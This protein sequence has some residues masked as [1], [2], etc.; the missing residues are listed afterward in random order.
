MDTT[1]AAG[2]WPYVCLQ[3]CMKFCS[4]AKNFRWSNHNILLSRKVLTAIMT[5]DAEYRPRCN[6]MKLCSQTNSCSFKSLHS[7]G[8]ALYFAALCTFD[9]VTL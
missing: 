7:V 6:C 2:S 4:Q 9:E 1:A 8:H 3:F 5:A